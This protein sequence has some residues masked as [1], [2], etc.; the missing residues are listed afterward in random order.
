MNRSDDTAARPDLTEE[1]IRE[2][3]PGQRPLPRP[4]LRFSV[5]DTGSGSRVTVVNDGPLGGRLNG[6]TSFCVHW[7]EEC[8]TST[9]AGKA[10]GFKRTVLLAPAIP[11]T[12]IDHTESSALYADPKYAAGYFF[13]TGVDAEGRHS[14][15]TEPARVI[16]GP[17]DTTIPGPVRH[18]Q[19]SESGKVSNGTVFSEL[20]ITALP[21]DGD[22]SNFGWLQLYLKDYIGLGTVQEAYSHRWLGS[23]GINFTVLYP[24]PRRTSTNAATATN[25]SANVSGT[26]FL[27]IAQAGDQFELLGFKSVI[28]AVTDTQLTL[29]DAWPKANVTTADFVIVASVTVYGVAVSKAGTRAELSATTPSETVLM[30]GEISVPNAPAVVTATPV[31]TGVRIAWDQ[32]AG[33]TIKGY[34]VYRSDGLTADTGMANSPPEPSVGTVLIGT[35]E[36]N[37]NLPAGS[38]YVGMQWDDTKFTAY[39]LETNAVFTW[40]VTTLNIRGDESEAEDV[41]DSCR[42]VLPNELDPTLPTLSDPKNYIYNSFVY[43]TPAN[44]V[45]ANDTSQDTYT[46][47]VAGTDEPGK[48]FGSASGQADG[49]GRFR[50]YTRLESNDGGTGATGTVTFVNNN[51]IFFPAPGAGNAHYCYGEIGAW[52]HATAVFRKIEKGAVYVLSCYAR[53]TGVTCDGTFSVLIEQYNDGTFVGEC[54]LRTRDSSG[55]LTAV[56]GAFELDASLLVNDYVR[57]YGVFQMDSSLA[58]SKQLRYTF[59]W[60]GG[61]V[62]EI[63]VEKIALQRAEYPPPWTQDMGDPT[64]SIPNPTFPT[65]PIGDRR[66]ERSGDIYIIME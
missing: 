7:C 45:L 11:A 14:E 28:T 2:I 54:L 65:E 44:Q 62:G 53:N 16:T 48:P 3:A 10:A 59:A 12:G 6:A 38:T 37:A 19:V 42:A 33:S 64:V 15:P 18:F 30:D 20:S 39:E 58:N 61:T 27:A 31:A 43:G 17:I 50:G 52:D 47:A 21:P 25:A 55:V 4:P 9:A 1:R 32:V 56:A 46:G 41:S 60:I 57:H 34:N 36:Q 63:R 40:Y 35:A 23:G 5:V 13:L 22:T 51:E 66:R 8:D 29:T 24:I 49:I 26:G